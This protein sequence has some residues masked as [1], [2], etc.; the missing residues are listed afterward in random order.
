MSA[1]SDVN[2]MLVEVVEDLVAYAA[3]QDLLLELATE[4]LIVMDAELT[5]ADAKLTVANEFVI[6]ALISMIKHEENEKFA[7]AK[8]AATIKSLRSRAEMANLPIDRSEVN[9]SVD[10]VAITIG[11]HRDTR[12]MNTKTTF[13]FWG[14][15]DMVIR[16]STA[17]AYAKVN[18]PFLGTIKVDAK[19]VNT[20]TSKA[21]GSRHVIENVIE[22]TVNIAGRDRN[23]RVVASGMVNDEGYGWEY[24]VDVDVDG[25]PCKRCGGNHGDGTLHFE[26]LIS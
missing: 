17:K 3:G 22:F 20:D 16:T 21:S 18:L 14:D 4:A 1:K 8:L 2:G 13:D 23:V 9:L 26:G 11:V 12:E 15:P 7:A 25:Q 10:N 5:V 19:M 24:G 6:P